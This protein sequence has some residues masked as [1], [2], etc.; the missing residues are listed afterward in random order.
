MPS[1]GETC[2][3]AEINYL[4]GSQ[5]TTSEECINPGSSTLSVPLGEPSS[6]DLAIV[7]SPVIT[8]PIVGLKNIPIKIIQ[9]QPFSIETD[10]EY[11]VKNLPAGMSLTMT[12]VTK[13]IIAGIPTVAGTFTVEITGTDSIGNMDFITLIYSIFEKSSSIIWQDYITVRTNA[14]SWFDAIDYCENLIL[15]G[16]DDWKLPTRAYFFDMTIESPFW[17][18]FN[19]VSIS[20]SF[21]NGFIQAG[22][23][24]LAGDSLRGSGNTSD[25]F[26]HELKLDN[27]D[28]V[29]Q[30]S[31][32]AEDAP[33]TQD[34]W[35]VRCVVGEP[36]DPSFPVQSL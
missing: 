3:W 17:S 9:L 5:A 22:A 27:I 26:V 13:A 7:A 4:D 34:F 16:R 33:K 21:T 1:N 28:N 11:T 10:V 12:D 18:N 30:P 6:A 2:F 25:I 20:S 29:G 19:Q 32:I 14:M 35:G 15:K 8:A 24:W 23:Y 31:A 36:T